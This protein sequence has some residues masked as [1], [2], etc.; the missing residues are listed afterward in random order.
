[1]AQVEQHSPE[2][3]MHGLF[4]KRVTDTVLDAMT[5]HE[6]LAMQVLDS[7][8]KGREF[9]LLI[10]RLLMRPER[11]SAGAGLRSG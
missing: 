5:D 4:P 7:P 11:L 8:E 6:K 9:A 2:Q 1:M 10:L 3:V